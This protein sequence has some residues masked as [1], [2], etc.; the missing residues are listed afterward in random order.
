[1]VLCLLDSRLHW[2]LE[3]LVFE[4]REKPEYP[5]K[6]LSEQRREP[7]TNSTHIWYW[8]RDLSPGHIGGRRVLSPLCYPC[9]LIERK[10]CFL[11]VFQILGINKWQNLKHFSSLFNSFYCR[12]GPCKQVKDGVEG[13]GYFLIWPCTMCTRVAARQVTFFAP[14]SLKGRT[15]PCELVLHKI[16]LFQKKTADRVLKQR[17]FS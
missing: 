3:L 17:L 13:E 16:L 6:N 2:N 9:S 1:M 11:Y 10:T 14:L 5:E 12:V 8:R 7:T 15:I 4:K